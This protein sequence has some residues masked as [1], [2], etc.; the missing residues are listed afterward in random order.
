MSDDG[1]AVESIAFRLGKCRQGP[2]ARLHTGGG[3]RSPV[4]QGDLQLF[5]GEAPCLGQPGKR[6]GNPRL[7]R[8]ALAQKL[9]ELIEKRDLRPSALCFACAI[10]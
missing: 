5:P 4:G 7:K 10:P 2:L 3:D 9:P 6:L 1:S 8:A